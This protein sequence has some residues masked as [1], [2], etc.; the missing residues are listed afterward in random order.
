MRWQLSPEACGQLTAQGQAYIRVIH[1]SP[2]CGQS[3]PE[4]GE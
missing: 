3:Y 4:I 2:R 1:Q